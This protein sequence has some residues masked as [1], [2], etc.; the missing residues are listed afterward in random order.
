MLAAARAVQ[1]A[2]MVAAALSDKVEPV[3]P[4]VGTCARKSGCL[5]IC[6]I[7]KGNKSRADG[8][9][10]FCLLE[11]FEKQKGPQKDARKKKKSQVAPQPV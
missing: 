1:L 9:F 11:T 4:L 7:Q 8:L 2:E 5:R 3:C 6:T 10:L